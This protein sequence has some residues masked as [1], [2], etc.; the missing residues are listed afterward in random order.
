MSRKKSGNA[1]KIHQQRSL[2]DHK[3][4]A[5]L[6]AKNLVPFHDDIVSKDF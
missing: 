1:R 2:W 6:S 3:H 4:I 5:T